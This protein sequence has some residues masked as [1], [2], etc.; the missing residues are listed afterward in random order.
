MKRIIFLGGLIILSAAGAARADYYLQ[1]QGAYALPTAKTLSGGIGAGLAAGWELS[2][3]V[4]VE[5]GIR[6]LC[7]SSANSVEGLSLGRLWALPVEAV[8]KGRL[9]LGSNLNLVGEAGA[10]YAI[11]SFKPDKDFVADW[12]A[13]GFDIVESVKNGVAVHFGAGCEYVLSP[14]LSLDFT[15][16]YFILPTTGEWSIT[17]AH[18]GETASGTLN[19]LSFDSFTFSLGLKIAL[20]GSGESR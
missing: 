5:L 4:S 16:R 13:V 14:T 10:G 3:Q 8:L 20:S 12:S 11:H 6:S 18:S 2:P 7:L 9:P 1:V 15:V 17:D 19:N